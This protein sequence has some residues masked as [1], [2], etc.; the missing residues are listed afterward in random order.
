MRIACGRM[1][2]TEEFPITVNSY[3]VNKSI[4]STAV[5]SIRLEDATRKMMDDMSDVNW[6]SE[7]RQMVEDLVREKKKQRFLAKAREL[8]QKMKPIEVSAA[9]MIRVDRDAR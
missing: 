2:Q 6:Q 1:S 5:Y 3:N 7:I 8:R 4:M 9:E